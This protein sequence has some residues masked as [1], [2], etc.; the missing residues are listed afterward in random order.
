MRINHRIVDRTD[1][2]FWEQIRN[3]DLPHE[4]GKIISVLNITEDHEAWPIVEGLLSQFDLTRHA[5][6]NLFSRK[7][8]DDADWLAAYA[9][10][11]HGYPQ[12]E[13]C[14]EY[15]EQTYDT[16]DYCPMCG[17]GGVQKAPFRFRAEPKVDHSHFLQLNWV[18]DEFFVRPE[19]RSALEESGITGVSFV[20][21]ILHKKNQPIE[22]VV[23]MKIDKAL[24]EGPDI[25]DLPS[26]TCQQYNEEFKEDRPKKFRSSSMSYCHR[27]KYHHGM[28]KGAFKF[29]RYTFD[30][31]PDVVKSKEWFGSS[32]LAFRMLI[33][34][35]RFR[36]IVLRM[37]WRGIAFK[38]LELVDKPHNP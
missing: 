32:A 18:F 2:P 20:P 3:L 7:E 14:S 24:V 36:D 9:Q 17:I 22:R 8:I 1:S 16:T 11:H 35:S 19:V 6:E 21:P 28:Q 12:P 15:I 37:K 30:G 25:S 26:V 10:G 5:I 29:Y 38:P 31:M 4:P 23:Q 27:V 34:S 13:D 33:V